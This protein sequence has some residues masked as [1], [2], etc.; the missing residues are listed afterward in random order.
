MEP[1]PMKVQPHDQQMTIRLPKPL[2]ARVTRIA[3]RGD[4]SASRLIRRLVT[5]GLDA[6]A[7]VS[8]ASNKKTR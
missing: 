7:A 2:H 1:S 4:E 8:P 6:S 3:A 5:R